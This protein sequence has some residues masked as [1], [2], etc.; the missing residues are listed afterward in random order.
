[1]PVVQRRAAG[2]TDRIAFRTTELIM[3]GW[4]GR[5]EAAVRHHIDEL[6]ALGVPPPSRVPL[7]YRVDAALLAPAAAAIDVLGDTTSGEVEPVLVALADGLWVGVGSDHTDRAMEAASVA[8]SKQLCRKPMAAE[9]W[10]F[11]EVV[12]HWD[13]LILRARVV[14]EGG[15]WRTYQEGRLAAI[16]H[17]YELV[18]AYLGADGPLPAGTVM[19]CGTLTALGGIRPA[20]RFE[21]QLEDP[22]LR[23]SI[24]HGYQVR[25]LPVVG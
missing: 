20:A 2:G 6:A 19:F 7:F 13:E 24:Q 12:G 18:G 25:A 14:D 11:D 8:H 1:M 10:R 5:D 3:A 9:L 21:M 23:R 15:G 17:P 22:V 4:T 16:R